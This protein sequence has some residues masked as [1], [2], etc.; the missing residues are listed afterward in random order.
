M[1]DAERM[2]LSD[3]IKTAIKAERRVIRWQRACIF[4]GSLAIISILLHILN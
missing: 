4:T 2:L 1:T 3:A